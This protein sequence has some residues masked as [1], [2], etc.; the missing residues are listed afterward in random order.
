MDRSIAEAPCG[1]AYAFKPAVNL[2]LCVNGVFRSTNI[3]LAGASRR[4]TR[5]PAP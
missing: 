1:N 3:A 4:A 5:I 2:R